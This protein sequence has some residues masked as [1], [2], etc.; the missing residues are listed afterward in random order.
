MTD[1]DDCFVLEAAEAEVKGPV[2]FG[3][4]QRIAI[5]ATIAVLVAIA[6]IAVGGVLKRKTPI[7]NGTAQKETSIV[8]RWEDLA[9]YEKY[10]EVMIRG[11]KY[12]GSPGMIE[13]EVGQHIGD[14]L[15]IGVDTGERTFSEKGG[16][17]KENGE[18]ENA[19]SGLWMAVDSQ[20]VSAGE[21]K[22]H[23]T[24][25]GVYEIPGIDPCF[26][27]AVKFR[28]EEQYFAYG[29]RLTVNTFAE[30]ASGTQLSRY[31]DINRIVLL[32]E[33]GEQDVT[34]T[35]ESIRELLGDLFTEESV[36]AFTQED[37]PWDFGGSAFWPDDPALSSPNLG[38]GTTVLIVSDDVSRFLKDKELGKLC[39][40]ISVD[41]RLLGQQNV[42]IY[43]YS[44]GF[45]TTNIGWFGH[46][47]YVGKE[48]V[49][50]FLRA[51]R[52]N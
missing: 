7:G 34:N 48:Q 12:F 51:L 35:Y 3:F 5:V 19:R 24:T 11:T 36:P 37:L 44:G 15:L 20:S 8:K 33:T 10:S 52:G 17:E 27:V 9:N 6:G 41:Y 39:A 49:E 38:S 43:V 1:V 46:T 42:G 45:V 50:D 21:T 47:F 40:E 13:G 16:T 14:F 4:G 30:F 2:K 32:T 29:S 22:T 25:V 23:E 28:E 31:T 26:A 18:S